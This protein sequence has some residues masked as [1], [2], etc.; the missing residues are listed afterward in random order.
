M[1]ATVASRLDADRANAV[2]QRLRIVYGVEVLVLP[3][4]FERGADWT[5]TPTGVVDHHDAST[6]KSG[7]WG[8]LGVVRDGRPD[9]PGPLAQWQ[10]ARCLDGV[11]RVAL[12]AAGR[13]NHAGRGGPLNGVP[14]DAGNAWL[15]G[16][17]W[18][19]DGVAEP[20]TLAAHYA[21]DALFRS[22]ADVCGFGASRVV[23]HKE[24]AVGRKSDPLYSM[25]WRRA[26]V[27]GIQPRPTGPAPQRR[28]S[29][30]QTVQI[31]AGNGGVRLVVPTGGNAVVVERAWLSFA[32]NGPRPGRV[33]VWWQRADGGGLADTGAFRDVGFANGASKVL[34]FEVPPGTAQASIQW[35]MPDGGTYTVETLARR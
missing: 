23:G 12:V 5:R 22:I 16:V 15:V 29:E 19:N 34:N 7:E 14:P 27:A 3:G 9:L 10:G 20:Y 30:L 8:A 33:R 26:G 32:V 4:A 25:S 2:V 21:H 1:A 6:R 35:E 17:E 18:A 28:D 11:P 24:W 13:A 31:A